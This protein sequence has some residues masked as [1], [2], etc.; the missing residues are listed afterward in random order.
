MP[1]RGAAGSYSLHSCV[2]LDA[3]NDLLQHDSAQF[4]A[5]LVT[6]IQVEE[7]FGYV[8][9]HKSS[10]SLC[11][12]VIHPDRNILAAA[13]HVNVD[14]PARERGQRF[15]TYDLNELLQQVHNHPIFCEVCEAAGRGGDDRAIRSHRM[16]TFPRA[17][18]C[19]MKAYDAG[20]KARYHLLYPR[21]LD[22]APYSENVAQPHD[23]P[24]LYALRAIVC[25][26]GHTL[27]SGHYIAW[28]CTRSGHWCVTDDAH[29]RPRFAGEDFPPNPY[30]LIY[31][32]R[33]SIHFLPFMGRV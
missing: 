11:Q 31:V 4:L 28:V 32:R 5:S 25:H 6:A 24:V 22:L 9:V 18:V 21:V 16:R 17:Y 14:L 8:A 33:G 29:V 13:E 7:V 10:C 2:A 23:P 20:T 27:E 19:V 15:P 26:M 12:Y 30:M 1:P 3:F